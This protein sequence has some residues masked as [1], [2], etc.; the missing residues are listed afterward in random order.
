MAVK[1]L[2]LPTRQPSPHP[3]GI[4]LGARRQRR[5]SDKLR[6]VFHTACDEGALE[7]AE[8]LLNYLDGLI[9]RPSRLPSGFDRRRPERLTA[10]AERL[11]NLLLW[12][13]QADLVLSLTR[14]APQ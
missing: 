10:L 2:R 13:T 7:H 14:R 9:H 5:L 4:R 8:L 12:H 11:A 3:F 1:R 6:V